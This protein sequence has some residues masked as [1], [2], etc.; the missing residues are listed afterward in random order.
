MTGTTR[1]RDEKCTTTEDCLS[2]GTDSATD[3]TTVREQ[4]GRLAYSNRARIP[5]ALVGVLVLVGGVMLVAHVETQDEP[6]PDIDASLAIDRTE[7]V[8]Q[9]AVRD[10]IRRATETATQQPLTDPATNQWGDILAGDTSGALSEDPFM[11]YLRAVIYLEV[12]QN[13]DT[14]GQELGDVETQVSLPAVTNATEFEKAIERVH[15]EETDEPGVMTVELSNVTLTAT[16]RGDEIERIEQ[17]IAVSVVTPILE[18]HDR[19]DAY[20]TALDAGLTE[21]GFTQRFNARIYGLG[22][23]RGWAQNARVPIVEVIAN[24]HIEPSA[25]SALYR[26]QQDIFGA[27]DPALQG[28]VQAGWTCMFMQDGEAFLGDSEYSPDIGSEYLDGVDADAETLCNVTDFVLDPEQDLELD[29]D[30]FIEEIPG[31]DEQETLSVGGT[32]S[33]PLAHMADPTNEQSFTAALERLFTIDTVVESDV[34]VTDGLTFDHDCAKS[35]NPTDRTQRGHDVS[36]REGERLD[37][38]DGK[39]YELTALVSVRVSE[40]CNDDNIV[41]DSDIDSLE[42]VVI[43]TFEANETS[44]EAKIDRW[45]ETDTDYE[46]ESGPAGPDTPGRQTAPAGFQNYGGA[47]KDGIAQSVLREEL[48]GGLSIGDGGSG[49]E[50]DGCFTAGGDVQGLYGCWVDRTL[51]STGEITHA[52]DLPGFDTQRQVLVDPREYLDGD[53]TALIETMFEDINEIRNSVA[54]INHTFERQDLL[55]TGDDNPFSRLIEEINAVKAEY[56]DRSSYANVGEKTVYEVRLAYFELLH[57][58]FEWVEQSH[59][60]AIGQLEDELDGVVGDMD[61]ALDFLKQGTDDPAP[62]DTEMESAALTDDVTFE[63]SGSPTYLESANLTSADVPAIN[64]DV[65]F[66]PLAMR[67]EDHIDLPYEEVIDSLL[68]RIA[69]WLRQ[70]DPEAELSFRMAGDVLEAADRAQSADDFEERLDD[71]DEFTD[72]VETLRASVDEGID[73]FES[74]AANEITLVL[75]DDRVATCLIETPVIGP[76]TASDG[77]QDGPTFA[78]CIENLHVA[79]DEYVDTIVTARDEI[80]AAVGE[81][82]ADSREEHGIAGTADAIGR[83]TITDAVQAAVED[84]LSDEAYIPQG[85]PPEFADNDFAQWRDIVSSAVVP[86]VEYGGNLRIDIGDAEDAEAID[87]GIQAAL[88]EVSDEIIDGRMALDVDEDALREFADEELTAMEEWVGDWAGQ[89]TRAARVPAGL[90]LLPIPGHWYAT[91]NGWDVRVTGEYA[92]FEATANV[93]TPDDTTGMTYVREDQSVEY[94]IG[95]EMRELGAVDSIAF[96]SQSV[97]LVIV[98]PGV[99]VGDRDDENPECS[100]TWP[101]SGELDTDEIEC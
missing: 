88:G 61:A 46:F 79:D 40:S 44:P 14:A 53:V 56:L 97:L 12:E 64:Q 5:L 70:S 37:D 60:D 36:V 28:A 66:V 63:V 67:N 90:P 83:A 69:N 65:E 21:R 52:D 51:H 3:E 10:G 24:R 62:E 78:E 33:L 86:G 45:H 50:R 27:A 30:E 89:Q 54:A 32:A 15:I 43:S 26:T 55:E 20:E 41:D 16:H 59:I 80:E 8:T 96:D 74:A 29:P 47:V 71:P 58:Q 23:L 93:G 35:N 81:V 49:D 42:V 4:L 85:W 75:Y 72:T 2:A 38:P 87:E 99:G 22:Y 31:L 91:V 76:D 11:N 18:L 9:T 17:R 95:G 57:S 82:L 100:P 34:S 39:L 94:E 19:V 7:S 92:R 101:V 73:E 84:A 68:G 25:N 6:E 13:L 77:R 98:P 48:W 1:P